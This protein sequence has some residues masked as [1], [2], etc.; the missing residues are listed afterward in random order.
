ME[1]AVDGNGIVP[2][3][4]HDIVPFEKQAIDQTA[5]EG[6]VGQ[7]GQDKA[8]GKGA[9]DQGLDAVRAGHGGF[10]SWGIGFGSDR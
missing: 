4:V 10:R 1:A 9:A 8:L 5:D 7:A 3:K 6:A 2:W